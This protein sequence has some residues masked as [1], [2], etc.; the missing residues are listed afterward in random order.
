M[1]HLVCILQ[2]DGSS[3]KRRVVDDP[4]MCPSSPG[5]TMS[6]LSLSLVSSRGPP[7]FVD[8][9]DHLGDSESDVAAANAR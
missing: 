8:L 1:I 3:R 5:L 6:S 9:L 4:R 2:H 7:C